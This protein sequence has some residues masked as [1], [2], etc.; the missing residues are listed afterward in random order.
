MSYV[1]YLI[2]FDEL[3]VISKKKEDHVI[4]M[5]NNVMTEQHS[6]E[7]GGDTRNSP[8][9]EIVFIDSQRPGLHISTFLRLKNNIE[10][11]IRF[12]GS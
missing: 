10:K 9:D 7:L 2:R 6:I 1:C 8:P 4:R 12:F 5:N 3:P 11:R